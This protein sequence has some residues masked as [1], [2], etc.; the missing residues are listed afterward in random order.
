MRA[1][2]VAF[3]ALG[4]PVD[5][6][7]H[8]CEMYCDA[9][10]QD[11]NPM[12]SRTEFAGYNMGLTAT[13]PGAQSALSCPSLATTAKHALTRSDGAVSNAAGIQVFV[14]PPSGSTLTLAVHASDILGTAK[15]LIF[16]RLGIP[17]KEQR[18]VFCGRQLEDG[19]TFSWCRVQDG[20][21]LMLLLRLRGGSAVG[22]GLAMGILYFELPDDATGINERVTLLLFTML[23][24]AIIN[25]L[26][27]VVAVLPELAVVRKEARN[28]W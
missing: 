12:A 21:T 6:T 1:A 20:S 26:P 24:M 15:L 7:V 2:M 8:M 22:M 18:L 14:K 25:A 28:N 27:V 10:S 19:C 13:P 9:A 17:P 11:H 4:Y 16:A 3:I 23:F 5:C